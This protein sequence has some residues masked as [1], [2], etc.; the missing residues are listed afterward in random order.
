MK[1]NDPKEVA[2]QKIT[3]LQT[4]GPVWI[5]AFI[6]LQMLYISKSTLE[7]WVK[8]HW[9][10]KHKIA[11]K[12]FYDKRQIDEFIEKRASGISREVGKMGGLEVRMIG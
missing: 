2:Q 5:D 1:K 3:L 9:L 7:R 10:T 8:K 11:G 6:A 12:S 4:N